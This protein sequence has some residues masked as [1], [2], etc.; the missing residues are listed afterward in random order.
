ME[1]QLLTLKLP[2]GSAL[3]WA[4]QDE[5]TQKLL[6]SILRSFAPQHHIPAT[7]LPCSC[8]VTVRTKDQRLTWDDMG[9]SADSTVA[10]NVFHATRFT[11]ENE[12]EMLVPEADDDNL[13]SM[14]YQM[15]RSV[16]CGF[17]PL[18]LRRRQM[19]IHGALLGMG[20]CGVIVC[21]PPGAG[22]S[23]CARRV[24]SPWAALAD[25]AILIT[26]HDGKYF[27][28]GMPTWSCY[29]RNSVSPT[30]NWNRAVRLTGIFR[31]IQNDR[32]FIEDIPDL[33]KVAVALNQ[34]DDIR[35][36]WPARSPQLVGAMLDFASQLAHNVPMQKLHCSL[37]GEF[38]RELEPFV[39]L[40]A[41]E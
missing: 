16:W 28:Q 6:N 32:D 22:K 27:A 33:E 12:V 13:R 9:W 35:Y 2:G 14:Y 3:V 31:L 30:L 18:A 25:D 37:D 38:W 1:E 17:L 41:Q 20:D 23:T 40:S 39:S 24:S 21:G 11:G 10:F 5:Y 4:F 7:D 19:T 36:M 26:E 34:I 8:R 15:M 29:Q